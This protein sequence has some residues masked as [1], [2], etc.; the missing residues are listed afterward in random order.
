[1]ALKP[2]TIHSIPWWQWTKLKTSFKLPAELEN[3]FPS[4][5]NLKILTQST[6]RPI[7]VQT[8][9]NWQRITCKKIFKDMKVAYLLNNGA[10]NKTWTLLFKML[11][12]LFRWID[13]L[14]ELFAIVL[15]W[16]LKMQGKCW[17]IFINM[18]SQGVFLVS[19]FG[20]TKIITI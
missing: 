17:K 6:G 1:M 15:W 12:N 9:L 7:S 18:L 8:W 10:K 20:E 19:M 3:Y 11:N 5:S 14:I 2:S 4:C 16:S 13:P